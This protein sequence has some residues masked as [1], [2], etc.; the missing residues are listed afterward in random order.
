MD[1]EDIGITEYQ[2]SVLAKECGIRMAKT[3]LFQ[4]KYFGVER[5]DRLNG[6]KIHT[7]SAA[8]LLNAN[9]REPSLDYSDLLKV[10][11]NLTKNMEEVYDL[12]RIMLF[13]VAIR[14]RDDHAKNFSFQLI[15]GQ[16]RLSPAYDLL[17]SEGFNGFHTTTINNT[18]DPTTK[19]IMA[20]AEQLSLDKQRVDQ[21]MGIISS[22]T[23][24]NW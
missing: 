5:F 1:R 9:Y 20:I 13:N 12:F 3:K 21:M 6:Q 23:A 4:D 15:D 10:T 22:K 17:P 11:L 7:I 19:D 8:G 18:G 2:H 24:H 16:W 14:N